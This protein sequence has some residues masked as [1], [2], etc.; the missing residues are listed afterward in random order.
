MPASSAPGADKA[1]PVATVAAVRSSITPRKKKKP[2]HQKRGAIA[3]RLAVAGVWSQ[4][5]DATICAAVDATP[6]NHGRASVESHPPEHQ[7]PGYDGEAIQN[8]YRLLRRA[9]CRQLPVD[10]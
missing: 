1:A 2:S 8:R 10:Y 3:R 9:S 6:R 5:D 4:D 7:T